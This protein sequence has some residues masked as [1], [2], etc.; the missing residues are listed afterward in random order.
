MISL[1]IDERGIHIAIKKRVRELGLRFKDSQAT[2]TLTAG[3]TNGTSAT[4]DIDMDL[5]ESAPVDVTAK[6]V[7]EVI[8]T[9]SEEETE[10]PKDVPEVEK[11]AST[12]APTVKARSKLFDIKKDK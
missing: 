1:T 4:I 5:L 6:E 9:A 2:V 3:R 7:E 12:V 11:T 10:T 8:E